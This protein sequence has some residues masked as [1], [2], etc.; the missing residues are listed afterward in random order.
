[1]IQSLVSEC[2]WIFPFEKIA[3]I[4]GRPIKIRLDSEDQLHA[5]GE[6]AVL[7]AD[8]F[9]IWANHGLILPEKYGKLNPNKWPA[10]WI[11]KER[12]IN[13]KHCLI[14]TIS[15]PKIA[16]LTSEQESRIPVIRD[17]WRN[18]AFSTESIDRHK[19][20]EAVKAVYIALGEQEPEVLFCDSPLMLFETAARYALF[21]ESPQRNF[22]YKLEI[23]LTI[24]W[25]N[26]CLCSSVKEGI[27]PTP[28]AKTPT[29]ID[30][31]SYNIK[32][33]Q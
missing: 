19:A 8:G 5:E 26:N 31:R 25:R 17:K 11:A 18:Y 20:K 4:C 2:G 14:K 7:F 21:W 23:S 22:L 29:D 16:H 28:P 1:V 12:D 6:P 24:N 15:P 13:L 27:A 10:E 9:C 32:L 33:P 30:R 3:I